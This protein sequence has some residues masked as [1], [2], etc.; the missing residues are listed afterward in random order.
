M[1][2][3]G[4]D[5]PPM[6]PRPSHAHKGS[7]GRALLVAGS[8][9]MAGAATLAV[10]GA[11]R[12]GAGYAVLHCPSAVGPAV[13]AHYP[14]AVL[15]LHDHDQQPGAILA[16]I[17]QADAVCIGP[18]LGSHEHTQQLVLALLEQM[19]ST[20]PQKPLLL[21]ADG[22]NHV[23]SSGVSLAALGMSAMVLT[24]HPGEAARLLSWSGAA[25]VQSQRE[26]AAQQLA[27]QTG[28][29]VVLKGEGSLVATAGSVGSIAKPSSEPAP[30]KIWRNPS[31]NP[32]MATAGSGDVLSGMLTALLARG[33]APFDASRLATYLHG[34][35]GDLAAAEIGQESLIASDLIRF[36]PQAILK[37][38]AE[39]S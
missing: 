29:V 17:E 3:T 30:A 14:E 28:A 32:G 21:D 25:E 8:R 19:A 7:M 10:G 13:N 34:R 18:G 35:A 37:H 9:N 31:G 23:A 22:L 16:G 5:L 36:L 26:S 12:C 27:A 1:P 2:S 11:L 24:P 20:W 38:N 33:M 39:S 15:A 4:S 6:P